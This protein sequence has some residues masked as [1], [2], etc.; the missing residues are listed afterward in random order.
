MYNINS[1]RYQIKPIFL[2][3]DHVGK[4]SIISKYVDTIYKNDTNIEMYTKIIEIDNKNINLM[5]WDIKGHSSFDKITNLYIKDKNAF[6]IIF[7]LTNLNSFYNL[8]EWIKKIKINNTINSLYNYYPILLI[9]NKRDLKNKRRITYEEAEKYAIFNKL[10]Y[11]ELSI[12]DDIDRLNTSLQSYFTKIHNI[13]SNEHF[14]EETFNYSK[15]FNNI[16]I[17]NNENKT[18]NSKSIDNKNKILN[19]KSI[20]NIQLL[21]EQYKSNKTCYECKKHI[22]NC[23]IL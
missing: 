2:G 3:D 18:L 21:D 6:I 4:T 10:L 17:Y 16:N 7:D 5:I 11:I 14:I 12:Y 9:G 13:S 22:S 23:T 19:S 1:S 8:S 20:D 15:I